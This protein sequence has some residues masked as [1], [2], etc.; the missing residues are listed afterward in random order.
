VLSSADPGSS[1]VFGERVAHKLPI[2]SITVP[3]VTMKDL[4]S[5]YGAPFYVK[6]DIEG[7]NRICVL[8]F[9]SKNRPEYL[10]FEVRDDV[11]ELIEHARKIGFNKFKIAGQTSF[12]ELANQDRLYDQ[13]SRRFVRELGYADCCQIRRA[14]RFLISG[15]KF[16]SRPWESEGKWCSAI[17]ACHDGAGRRRLAPCPVGTTSTPRSRSVVTPARHPRVQMRSSAPLQSNNGIDRS[18]RP[19]LVQTGT[20]PDKGVLTIG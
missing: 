13:I 20:C 17:T 3:G 7:A 15:H 10:S 1:S 18:P 14:R 4:L 12:R 9:N 2:G 5:R 11:E 19:L 6:V 16:R 8:S